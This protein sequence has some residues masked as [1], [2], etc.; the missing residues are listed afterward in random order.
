M[1][2]AGLPPEFVLIV[3]LLTLCP[4]LQLGPDADLDGVELFAGER[5][6]TM[7]LRRTRWVNGTLRHCVSA[8]CTAGGAVRTCI[9]CDTCIL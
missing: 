1:V 8:W 4:H 7:A 9:R 2:A 6:V 3:L 5:A